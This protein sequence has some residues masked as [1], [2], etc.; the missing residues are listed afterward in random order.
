[1]DSKKN[2][3]RTAS[4]EEE[5]LEE[6][7]NKRPRRDKAKYEVGA[8]TAPKKS[9]QKAVRKPRKEHAPSLNPIPQPTTHHRP[10]AQLFVWGMAD[11]GQLGLG[12]DSLDELFKPRSHAF[13][14]N[15]IQAGRF[16]PQGAGIEKI[17]AGGMHSFMIDEE[18]KVRS[19]LMLI[20]YSR[21]RIIIL[22]QGLVMGSQ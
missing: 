22:F 16:G 3:K 17:A 10:P 11:N 6:A 21:S 14:E 12:T 2:L 7:T 19:F 13:C 9:S 4:S 8:H 15:A 20:S 1:M 5:P 18:G